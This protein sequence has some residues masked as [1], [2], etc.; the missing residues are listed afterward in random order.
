MAKLFEGGTTPPP[1]VFAALMAPSLLA[2]PMWSD[3]AAVE[4]GL[5]MA[6]M[7]LPADPVGLLGQ[8]AANEAWAQRDHLDELAGL[9]MPALAIAAEFCTAFPPADVKAAVDRM[10]DA[11]YVELPGA[12]HVALD[13]GSNEIV[14]RELLA[15]LAEHH[16]ARR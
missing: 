2:P 8:Y 15:F 10:P 14:T 3:R 13:P 5:A 7:F 11:R 4:A 16:P 6:A 9:D 12:P 1:E